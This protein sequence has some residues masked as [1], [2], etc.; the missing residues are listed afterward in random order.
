MDNNLLETSKIYL[1]TPDTMY[2]YYT[3]MRFWNYNTTDRFHDMYNRCYT[4]MYII[5]VLCTCIISNDELDH[6]ACLKWTETNQ[7]RGRPT[8]HTILLAHDVT[9][10]WTHQWD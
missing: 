10:I 5:Y 7:Q 9:D 4:C 2:R 1:N 3:D 8:N 6:T